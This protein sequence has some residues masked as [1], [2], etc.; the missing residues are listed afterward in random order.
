VC[1]LLAVPN[2]S[3]GRDR[4]RIDVLAA[5]VTP[6][7]APNV[8]V[9]DI[10]SDADHNRTVFTLTGPPQELSHAIVSLA[11][12]AIKTIDLTRHQGVHPRVGALDVAPIVYTTDA[13]R[14]VACAEALVLADRIA[15]E[16]GLPVFL[17][18]ALSEHGHT[19]AGL[20][21]GG[22][23]RLA[24][25]IARQELAPD[26][27]PAEI[28]RTAGAVLVA[29]RPP[30]VAFNVELA[31]PATLDTARAIAA[32]IRESGPAGLPGLRAI[33]VA[34]ASR[35][36]VQIS[37]NIEDHHKTSAADVIGA[38]AQY[39]TPAR[40]EL[41]GLAPAAALAAF[42]PNVELLNGRTIEDALSD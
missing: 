2:V 14:G 34:L 35:N 7:E 19:R 40:A 25:R 20:R 13:D 30:L 23:D 9:L 31:P 33:G 36:R 1:P 21:R 28:H 8:R 39:A 4:A 26:F 29:A 15:G 3:E 5:A 27:G 16:A 22:P 10:H 18:G 41:V 17:Y 11:R 12:A 24:A 32:Q 37:T 6:S 38:I 42:P